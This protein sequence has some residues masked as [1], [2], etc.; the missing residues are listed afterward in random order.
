MNKCLNMTYNNKIHYLRVPTGL[1]KMRDVDLRLAVAYVPGCVCVLKVVLLEVLLMVADQ[2]G[3]DGWYVAVC[4]VLWLDWHYQAKEAVIVDTSSVLCWIYF[5][6]VV[7]RLRVIM[8]SSGD[9]SLLF[10]SVS[11]CWV[12]MCLYALASHLGVVLYNPSLR[13]LRV[14]LESTCVLV[15][16]VAFCPW[17]KELRVLRFCRGVLFALLCVIWLYAV[18]LRDGRADPFAAKTIRIHT[19]ILFLPIL[20]TDLYVSVIFLICV[21]S[22]LGYSLAQSQTLSCGEEYTVLSSSSAA[23]TPATPPIESMESLEQMLREARARKNGD[24]V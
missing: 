2:F 15:S 7:N 19:V 18:D 14:S 9:I 16:C 20:F 6:C 10:M 12:C 5:S 11:V 1:S 17:S 4:L 3:V 22:L 8:G 21:C 23:E 24:T 13:G